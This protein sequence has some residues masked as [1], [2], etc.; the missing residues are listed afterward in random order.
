MKREDSVAVRY[1]SSCFPYFGRSSLKTG[2]TFSLTENMLTDLREGG[3]ERGRKQETERETCTACL[4][5]AP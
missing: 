4:S 2:I 1:Y 3:K 5:Y